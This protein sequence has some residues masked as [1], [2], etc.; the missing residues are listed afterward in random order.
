MEGHFIALLAGITLG[1]AGAVLLFAYD[2]PDGLWI[3]LAGAAAI[4]VANVL[5][6]RAHN[7]AIRDMR[8]RR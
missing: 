7:A 4:L 5:L 3:L 1:V 2:R 8:A 6:R